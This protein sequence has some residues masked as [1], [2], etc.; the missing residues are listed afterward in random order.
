LI[1]A[2]Y[3]TSTVEQL[4]D[5]GAVKVE[6]FSWGAHLFAGYEERAVA[7][8]ERVLREMDKIAAQELSMLL[9]DESVAG[10]DEEAV[11]DMMSVRMGSGSESEGHDGRDDS[12][13]E[14]DD[15]E[16][17]EV[18]TEPE[19]RSKASTKGK[20]KVAAKEKIVI[21]KVPQ[22]PGKALVRPSSTGPLPRPRFVA[23]HQCKY[24]HYDVAGCAHPGHCNVCRY[25]RAWG[26]VM[27]QINI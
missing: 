22:G 12:D 26:I 6:W 24:P 7:G 27:W 17:I 9:D 4:Y 19:T 15:D 5:S 14:E 16:I 2:N 25:T 20:G 23:N 11:A 21:E 3:F 1:I 13:E 10:N 18:D 8:R